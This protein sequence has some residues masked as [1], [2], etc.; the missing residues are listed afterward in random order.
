MRDLEGFWRRG[1]PVARRWAGV[2]AAG[3]LLL[4]RSAGSR[5]APGAL[6]AQSAGDRGHGVLL[7]ALRRHR[8][9]PDEPAARSCAASSGTRPWSSCSPTSSDTACRAGSTRTAPSAAAPTIL[10]EAQADCYAGV[11]LRRVRDGALPDLRTGANGIDGAMGALITF[12]DPVGTSPRNADAHGNAFDRVSSF[13]DGFDGDPGGVRVDGPRAGL[14]PA[15]VPL[16]RGREL[17]GQPRRRGADPGDGP[18]PRP[19][20]RRRGP[21]PRRAVDRPGLRARRPD[22]PGDGRRRPGARGLVRRWGRAVGGAHRDRRHA[23]GRPRP[24]RRLLDGHAA[25]VA[26]RRRRA[27]RARA[28]HHGRPRA[29]VPRSASPAPTAPPSAP[30]TAASAC[31]PAT[32]T[33]R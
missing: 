33:S 8:L 7:P 2:R 27:R 15:V 14:H 12:R 10:L 20:V 5:R 32:S 18:R 29:G 31:P 3:R 23:R 17:R 1:V 25:R 21:P 24:H 19:L 22:L 11:F 13:Q 30:A 6:P 9:G 16:S 4:G 26:L 28:A